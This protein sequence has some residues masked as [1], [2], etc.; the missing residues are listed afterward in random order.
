MVDQ[1]AQ[2]SRREVPSSNPPFLLASLQRV[3]VY[4]D[5]YHLT[6]TA[7]ISDWNDSGCWSP[8]KYVCKKKAQIQPAAD[9][10][11]APLS[12]AAKIIQMAPSTSQLGETSDLIKYLMRVLCSPCQSWANKLYNLCFSSLKC[13]NLGYGRSLFGG[14]QFPWGASSRRWRQPNCRWVLFRRRRRLLESPTYRNPRRISLGGS[15]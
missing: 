15:E 10:A 13:L 3:Q 9:Q 6:P 5:N 14:R 1:S 12:S 2:R 11:A 7:G 8:M 4:S